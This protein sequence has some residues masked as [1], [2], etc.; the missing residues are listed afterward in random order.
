MH[1]WKSRVTIEWIL[2]R[3]L[4]NKNIRNELTLSPMTE[5]R[6]KDNSSWHFHFNYVLQLQISANDLLENRFM[7]RG[8]KKTLTFSLYDEIKE[9][10]A[11]R[12][13]RYYM[14]SIS[15]SPHST[16]MVTSLWVKCV[17]TYPVFL[18]LS[19]A[20]FFILP[21]LRASRLT[22]CSYKYIRWQLPW[23]TVTPRFRSS[24]WFDIGH[25]PDGPPANLTTS[26]ALSLNVSHK[27]RDTHAHFPPVWGQPSLLW[28]TFSLPVSGFS[29]MI[30]D[31][32]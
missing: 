30:E 32:Q 29:S 25:N 13:V 23:G 12:G 4:V 20:V 24:L 6:M 22:V 21:P 14:Q 10:W 19:V 31:T 9:N 5:I 26:S 16:F 28:K 2:Y 7:N 1:F 17:Q 18:L 11:L 3:G 8:R 27:H 15:H